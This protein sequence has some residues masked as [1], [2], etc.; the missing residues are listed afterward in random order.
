[1]IAALPSGP[2]FSRSGVE[3]LYYRPNISLMSDG[4]PVAERLRRVAEAGFTSFEV[5]FPRREGLA[6]LLAAKERYGLAV[7]LYNTEPDETHPR[8]YLTDPQGAQV[9]AARLRQEVAL[10]AQLGCRSIHCMIGNATPGL[11]LDQQKEVIV[12]RLREAVPVAEGEGLTLLIEAL[13]TTDMPGFSVTRSRDGFDIVAAVGSPNVRFQY[14]VYHMQMME[15]NLAST[16]RANVD[17]IGHIQ[18]ADVPGRYRPGTGEIN[19]PFLLRAIEEA[20]YAG[21]VGLEYKLLPGDPDPFVW[22]PREVRGRRP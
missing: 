6:E 8:G 15:G 5:M 1:M 19:F 22:L 21:Y 3:M 14:D 18:I 20:G 4:A 12:Q 13:N 2:R 10:A 11:T 7:G 17:K 9:W 16:I